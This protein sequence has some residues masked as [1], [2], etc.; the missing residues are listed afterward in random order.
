MAERP[1][2]S[3]GYAKRRTFLALAGSGAAASVAGCVSDLQLEDNGDD[4]PSQ[5]IETIVA[6]PSGGGTDRTGRQLVDV[7]EENIDPS[8]Y[9]T[10]VEGGG[11]VTGFTEFKN[12][13]PNGYTIGV[14]TIGLSIF[15][16]LDLADIT[17]EDFEPIMQYNADPASVTVHEDAPY[18]TIEEFVEYAEE[19]PGEIQ[20]STDGHGG[21][22]HL[23]GVGF[24]QEAGIELDYIGYD[25]GGPATTAVV[26]EEVDATMTSVPEVAP[27]VQDGPLELLAVM[28]DERM[29]LFPDVPTLKEVG[30]DFSL[31]AWRG[32]GAPAGTP[33][34][35]IEVLHDALY[36]A[37]QDDEFQSFMEQNGFET[38][39]RDP[40]EFGEFWEEDYNQFNDLIGSLDLE[41][42]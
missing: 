42:D 33:E 41:D 22:W 13:D 7:A 27:Q 23:A 6:F 39:Y 26:N 12:A 25:G 29:D 9:V 24:Q 11:G 10:N 38:V 30:Y 20:A 4:Y 17:G 16:P 28:G 18:G 5:D 40:E 32:I 15:E 34:D 21:I 1:E 2:T 31:G 37:Y 19:N 8:M 3:G 36:E 35:R 14:V